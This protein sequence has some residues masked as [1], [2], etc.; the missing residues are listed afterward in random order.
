MEAAAARDAEIARRVAQADATRLHGARMAQLQTIVDDFVT[1][2]R[3]FLQL[4]GGAW[5]QERCCGHVSRWCR[6]GSVGARFCSRVRGQQG[7]APSY[8][9]GYRRRSP[10]V[11]LRP[12]WKTASLLFMLLSL[13]LTTLKVS[14]GDRRVTL[15]KV[16]ARL[17]ICCHSRPMLLSLFL[18]LEQPMRA[19]DHPPVFVQP[20]PV[21]GSV[22]D[23][24]APE[25]F[26]GAQRAAAF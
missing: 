7:P 8:Y 14:P 18:I 3:Q 10:I 23:V 20:P 5:V 12:L 9:R 25:L 17:P 19:Q 16:T 22:D 21:A 13:L 4:P 6:Y 15:A 11:L 24:E 1:A 26:M 2:D